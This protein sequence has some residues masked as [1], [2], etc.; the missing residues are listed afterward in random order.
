MSIKLSYFLADFFVSRGWIDEDGKI[1]YV[2]G[3]DVIIS[4]LAQILL[5]LMLGI[6]RG[7][8]SEAIVYLAFFLTIR[9][10]CGGYHASTR[11]G[12]FV[13]FTFLYLI[14]DIITIILCECIG[15]FGMKVYGICSLIVAEF[16]FWMYAPVKN[17][18]KRYT[19]IWLI[20]AR[21]KSFVCLYL[22]YGLAFVMMFV[23]PELSGQIFSACNAVTLLILMKKW[24]KVN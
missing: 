18:R 14:A 23:L 5:I 17:D 12:C 3:V 21:K 6:I 22:W 20:G 7:R 10:Y 13:I 16:V 19:K 1:A 11:I 2:V 9:R 4:S 8:L 15:G 24:R